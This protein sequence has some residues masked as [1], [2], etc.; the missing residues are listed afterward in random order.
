MSESSH[1]RLSRELFLVAFGAMRGRL[2]P[3]VT[4][5]LVSILEEQLV[6]AGETL[7]SPGDVPD[8]FYF[9]R[10]GSVRVERRLAHDWVLEGPCILGMVDALL[11]RPRVRRAVART[12]LRLMTV[13][14]DDWLELLE[15]S[16]DLARLAVLRLASNV[17]HLEQ[18]RWSSATGA[19]QPEAPAV[20]ASGAPLSPVE[21][22][23]VLMDVPLLRGSGVQTLSD[24]A[25]VSEQLTLA[26]GQALFE[27]GAPRDR[28][29]LV[30]EGEIEAARESPDVVRRARAG[31]VVCG[32]AA[33]GEPALAWRAT[34]RV[35]TRLLAL[36]IEDWFDFME[37]HFDMVRSTL[38]ALLRE[39][40][41]LLD[42]AEPPRPPAVV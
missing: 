20:D 5:R 22:L 39:R 27:R 11:D 30:V 6:H 32:A 8:C 33:F 31:D 37:E 15:D 2:E 29:F 14:T 28:M 1:P 3:W 23:A 16:F 18:T 12:D 35:R 10:E 17:A 19:E 41:R 24:L 4:D 40:E 38:A 42:E 13:R 9:M 26:R 21:R 34:A 7:L 25:L 36:R